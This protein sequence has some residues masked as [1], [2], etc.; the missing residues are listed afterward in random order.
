MIKLERADWENVK[1]H[2]TRLHREAQI[3]II[4]AEFMLKKAEEEIKKCKDNSGTSET[5]KK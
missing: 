2:A 4:N 3:Q 5:S 1:E